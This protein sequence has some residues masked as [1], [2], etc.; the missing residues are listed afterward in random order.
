MGRGFHRR[1]GDG[2]R[3]ILLRPLPLASGPHEPRRV[4]GRIGGPPG[5]AVLLL[6]GRAEW[7]NAGGRARHPL[8]RSGRVHAHPQR[9]R[10]GHPGRHGRRR[11]SRARR[12]KRR[13]GPEHRLR[14]VSQ[15]CVP[16]ARSRRAHDPHRARRLMSAPPRHDARGHEPRRS[17]ARLPIRGDVWTFDR[18]GTRRGPQR[19]VQLPHDG[20]SCARARRL[21]R[22]A[23][24]EGDLGWL[25][26]RGN[27]RAAGAAR[28]RT[29]CGMRGDGYR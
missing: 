13:G 12:S 26:R 10:L 22:H 5:G 28:R 9:L 23:L 17:S 8:R 21:G 24:G 4:A 25:R 20:D 19:G 11:H 2:R 3:R 27:A 7:R 6:L 15:P 18:P 14:R 1:R 29:V 16:P